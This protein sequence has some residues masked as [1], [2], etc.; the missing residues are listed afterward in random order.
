[1]RSNNNKNNIKFFPK[2]NRSKLQSFQNSNTTIEFKDL[3]S[4]SNLTD[5]SA[6]LGEYIYIFEILIQF[7]T[8]VLKIVRQRS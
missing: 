5:L 7:K 3:I 4:K 6:G 1:M 2:Y 8:Y